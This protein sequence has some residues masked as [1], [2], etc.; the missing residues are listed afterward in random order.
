M[1]FFTIT[2]ICPPCKQKL[3][4]RSPCFPGFSLPLPPLPA[5]P[6]L[7][8]A[9]SFDCDILV[10]ESAVRAKEKIEVFL[11]PITD[12]LSNDFV[13]LAKNLAY[14]V[15][16][17]DNRPAFTSSGSTFT[18]DTRAGESHLSS[19]FPQCHVFLFC[20]CLRGP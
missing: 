1:I 3:I 8:I 11:P 18:I 16:F 14:V 19:P 12:I 2:L 6:A 17:K 15:A 10:A 5:P 13:G 9:K 20:F 4:N 7:P